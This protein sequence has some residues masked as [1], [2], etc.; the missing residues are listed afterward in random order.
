[1][2]A[3]L[4]DLVVVTSLAGR[5][6]TPSAQPG[7]MRVGGFGGV[8][9]LAAYLRSEEISL[10]VDATHPFAAV[11]RWHALDACRIEGVPRLRVERPPWSPGPGD[12]WTSVAS[13]QAAAALVV[14]RRPEH[15]F[16]TIGRGEL[17]VFTGAADGRRR[18][19][20]RSIEPPEPLTLAP[21]RVVLD[22]GPFTEASEAELMSANGIDLL[23]SKNSGGEATAAKLAAARLLGVEVIMVERPSSPPGPAASSAPEAARWVLQ[24]LVRRRLGHP[25]G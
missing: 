23:V 6:T 18:W 17:D 1:L 16:L 22:R 14:R 11:M 10:V 15:V 13:M 7:L 20:I 19:L 24:E 4:D 8:D 3:D 12:L 25:A 9:G 5:T 21:A 2:L